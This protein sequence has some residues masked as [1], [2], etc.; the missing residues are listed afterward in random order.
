MQLSL[1]YLVSFFVLV[2]LIFVSSSGCR[3]SE[4]SKEQVKMEKATN[5]EQEAYKKEY[6][7]AVK[8]HHKMQSDQTKEMT[9]Q[10]KKQQKQYNK[11][12]QRSLWDRLF[13]KKCDTEYGNG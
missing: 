9:K 5:K 7:A 4:V 3:T 2:F 13:R 6:E 11:A 1:K 10:S 12:K 8:K